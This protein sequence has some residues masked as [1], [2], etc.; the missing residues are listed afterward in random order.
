MGV[1]EEAGVQMKF[2]V[3]GAELAMQERGT[4]LVEGPMRRTMDTVV[5]PAVGWME[6]REMSVMR[7][8]GG[9]G[10]FL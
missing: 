3:L 9:G 8:A 4:T 7:S 2:P 1:R 6:E 5:M 10:G